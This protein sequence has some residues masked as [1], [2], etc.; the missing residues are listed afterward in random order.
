MDSTCHASLLGNQFKTDLLFSL[1]K[2]R[3]YIG[4]DF[5]IFLIIA[6]A[7]IR[8]SIPIGI[9]GHVCFKTNYV[10]VDLIAQDRKAKK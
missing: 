4:I 6:L 8:L 5:Q 2:K 1:L 9:I 10:Y 3:E 7:E